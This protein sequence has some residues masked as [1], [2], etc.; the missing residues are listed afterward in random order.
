MR[1]PSA[2]ARDLKQQS[3]EQSQLRNE[4]WNHGG[5][6]RSEFGGGGA[7]SVFDSE[8]RTWVQPADGAVES[9][10]GVDSGDGCAAGVLMATLLRKRH[11]DWVSCPPFLTAVTLRLGWSS[12]PH[13]N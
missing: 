2:G 3:G 4:R 9:R 8:H 5:V 1:A 10:V 12:W 7:D 6:Q 13:A 11:R